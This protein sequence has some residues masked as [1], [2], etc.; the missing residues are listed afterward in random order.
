MPDKDALV[1]VHLS[2]LDSF[3]AQIG[4]DR[5]WE[6]ARNLADA[7]KT[8]SGQVLIVDQGWSLGYKE[9]RPRE[10]LLKEIEE[11]TD[12]IWIDFDE[13]VH[14]WD[15]FLRELKE[16]LESLDVQEVL[17]A[18]M[19]YDPKLKSGCATTVYMYLRQYFNTRVDEDLVGCEE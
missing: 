4:K 18:G 2:T 15:D 7:I 11:R 16:Q 9:S 10:W 13:D 14:E 5:G 12:I 19:W 6:L 17:V 8:Y 3:T 1:V